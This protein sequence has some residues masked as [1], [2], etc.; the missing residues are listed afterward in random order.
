MNWLIFITGS[1]WMGKQ[2]HRRSHEMG[3][4]VISQGRGPETIVINGVI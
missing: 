3:L 1:S 2:F 4:E